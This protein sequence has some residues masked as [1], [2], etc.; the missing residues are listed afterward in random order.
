MERAYTRGQSKLSD[1]R[2]KSGI[3][4]KRFPDRGGQDFLG[5]IIVDEGRR[6]GHRGLDRGSA[7][8]NGGA[9]GSRKQAERKRTIVCD[10]SQPKGDAARSQSCELKNTKKAEIDGGRWKSWR[11]REVGTDVEG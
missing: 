7:S 2:S 8:E 6:R 5:E 4:A 1:H 3:N 11:W 9:L 10:G